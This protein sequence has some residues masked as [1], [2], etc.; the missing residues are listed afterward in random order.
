[1]NFA[2]PRNNPS[3][4]ILYIWK[5]I[6]LPS[7][8]LN[9]LIYTISFELFLFPPQK[10]KE[11][12]QNSIENKLLEKDEQDTI[13]LPQ[14]LNKKLQN[15]QIERK[16][17]ILSK[18][19]NTQHRVRAVNNFEMD[20][21][22]NFN[23]LLKAFLDKGTI[24]R[25]VSLSE[26]DFTLNEFNFEKGS[27]K[28]EYTGSKE[29]PYIIEINT[30]NKILNHNCHDFQTRRLENKKFCK[31]LAKLFLLLKEKDEI[32]ATNFLSEIAQN[33]DKWEFA[34]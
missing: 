26:G 33:I 28:A 9:E 30:K 17:A 2:I 22:S 18:I 31:H 7:I 15:W 11:F 21:S 5:I 8:S 20:K 29:E 16:K 23:T 34:S 14:N 6:D 4:L 25:T 1:M 19:Q 3:E 32:S 24:N 10:V 27:I 13:T 12:I